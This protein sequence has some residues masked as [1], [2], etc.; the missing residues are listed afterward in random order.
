MK[1]DKAANLSNSLQFPQYFFDPNYPFSLSINIYVIRKGCRLP[2]ANWKNDDPFNS[3]VEE[4]RAPAWIP[5]ISLSDI[6]GI[7][8]VH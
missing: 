5:W 8:S 2:W 3:I 7:E 1:G 4:S 6:A